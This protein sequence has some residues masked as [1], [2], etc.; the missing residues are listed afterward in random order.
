MKLYPMNLI[1]E[2]PLN[3]NDYVRVNID[4]TIDRNN[5]QKPE[6]IQ[7]VLDNVFRVIL[8]QYDVILI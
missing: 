1:Y 7:E 6:H 4:L 5:V 8:R 3:E 2:I